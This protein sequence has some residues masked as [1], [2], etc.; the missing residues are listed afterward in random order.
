[1]FIFF[2]V[3]FYC[4]IVLPIVL[5]SN[6]QP[7]YAAYRQVIEIMLFFVALE[8][9]IKREKFIANEAEKDHKEKTGKRKQRP[10]CEKAHK[11]KHDSHPESGGE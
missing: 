8:L 9:K 1:M 11:K 7:N 5:Q 4:F 2:I 10:A 3:L 6:L